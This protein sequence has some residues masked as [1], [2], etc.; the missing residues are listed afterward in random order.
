MKNPLVSIV[1]PTYNRAGNITKT[2][3]SI[4]DQTYKNIELIIVDDGSTDNTQDVLKS[5]ADRIQYIYQDNAGPSAARNKG[6]QEAQGEFIAF[7]DS[8]DLWKPEKI[9]KQVELLIKA[10]PEVPC[11]ICNSTMD[12][13]TAENKN[14]F[15]IANLVPPYQEGIWHNV[16]EVLLSRFILFNQAIMVRKEA[17]N[18]AKGFDES[19]WLLEDHDLALSLALEGPW[20]YTCEPLVMWQHGSEHSLSESAKS[21]PV[22]HQQSRQK[23]YLNALE[24]LSNNDD[25]LISKVKFYIRQFDFNIRVATW[26][27]HPNALIKS[28]GKSCKPIIRL[29]DKLT[30]MRHPEMDVKPI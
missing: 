15:E 1:V 20:A 17:L 5:Y 4:L 13:Y 10:G 29:R 8:D 11:C 24:R 19:L 6:I 3:D 12:G 26:L 30:R 2:V 21:K 27:E 18:N 25:N 14:S 23:I 7:L 9:E 22:M 16:F 28:L